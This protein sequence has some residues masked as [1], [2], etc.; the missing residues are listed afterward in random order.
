VGDNWYIWLCLE[1]KEAHNEIWEDRLERINFWGMIATK[2][3]NKE[4]KKRKKEG[5]TNP[6]EIEWVA[7]GVTACRRTLRR[8]IQWLSMEDN[9]G[10]HMGSE[11]WMVC[12]I[13][14]ELIPKA[15]IAKWAKVSRKIPQSVVEHFSRL[16]CRF[17]ENEGRVKIWKP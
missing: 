13:L 1:S 16:S 9:E 2:H 7:A 5:E 12:H 11:K 15:F 6:K 4:K 17:I 14:R 3:Y 10:G 8:T